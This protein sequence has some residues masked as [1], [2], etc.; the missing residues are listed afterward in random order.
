MT[1]GLFDKIFVL[2]QITWFQV[3]ELKSESHSVTQSARPRMR[4]HDNDVDDLEAE[5]MG[6]SAS[7]RSHAV[8]RHKEQ[9][10]KIEKEKKE[11]QEVGKS[12]WDAI[13]C[14]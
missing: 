5:F 3:N 2:Q 1:L 9:L 12:I 7:V 11:Q 13:F 8:N 4:T 14:S 6:G 10:R